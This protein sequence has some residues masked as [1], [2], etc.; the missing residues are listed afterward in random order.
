MSKIG[1]LPVE[2]PAGVTVKQEGETFF[3]KGPKGELSREL[4]GEMVYE[5][6]EKEIAVKRPSDSKKHRAL[7]GLTRTLLANMVEGVTNGFTKTL[8]IQGVGFRAELKGKN[9]LLN[10]GYSHPILLVPPEEITIQVNSPTEVSVSGINKELVGLVAAKIRE[11][12]KPEPY[13]GKGIRYKGEMVR[14][15]AGKSG[16]A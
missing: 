3:V 8:E 14:R 9:L 2:I 5:F 11:F 7:H 16:K 13:K 6:N 1:K 15:K 10:L 12:R 4:S